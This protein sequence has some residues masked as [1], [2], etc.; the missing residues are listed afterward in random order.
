MLFN[1]LEYLIFLPLVVIIY[2][3]LNKRA[4]IYQNTFL[5]MMSYLFY[6]MWNWK[7]LFL[8]IL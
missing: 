6:G 3:W 4:I 7:F 2:W 1:S 8:L 5:L